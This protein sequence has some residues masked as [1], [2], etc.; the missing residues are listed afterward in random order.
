MLFLKSYQEKICVALF[1]GLTLSGLFNEAQSSGF[2]KELRLEVAVVQASISPV[3]FNPGS[4][5]LGT[6][7]WIREINRLIGI[8]AGIGYAM[9]SHFS[10]GLRSGYT[11]GSND[12]PFMLGVNPD[13]ITKRP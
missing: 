1:L 3:D 11:F 6:D 12:I 2:L 10:I 8:E 5:Q 9:S 7:E 4:V 13:K